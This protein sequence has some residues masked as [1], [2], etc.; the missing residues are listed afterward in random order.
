MPVTRCLTH[1]HSRR[2]CVIGCIMLAGC[3]RSDPEKLRKLEE[4]RQQVEQ[5]LR[6]LQ[7]E[8]EEHMQTGTPF[9]L[10]AGKRGKGRVPVIILRDRGAGPKQW[11]DY[12]SDA[13]AYR[14]Y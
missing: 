9:G 5:R 4:E 8:Y 2:I 13:S 3:S 12:D 6:A 1:L 10:D 14:C 7:R 11:C